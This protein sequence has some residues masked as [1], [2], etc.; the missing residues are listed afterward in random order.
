MAKCKNCDKKGFFLSVDRFNGLCANCSEVVLPQISSDVQIV[1]RS[2]KIISNSKNPKTIVSRCDD[3]LA[4]LSRLDP[5]YRKGIPTIVQ[6]LEEIQDSFESLRSE[7]AQKLVDEQV[8]MARAKQES[9]STPAGKLGGYGRAIENLNKMLLEFEDV[10]QIEP[11]IAELI[12]ERDKVRI[13]TAIVKAEKFLAKSKPKLAR[14]ALTDLLVE[15]RHDTTP[16]AEQAADIAR[17]NA[18]ILEIDAN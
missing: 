17:I 12:R 8:F 10:T 2:N 16:D 5:F 18:I 4:A 11:A 14:D 15:I 1:V 3:V 7:I 9:A 13:E 6:P